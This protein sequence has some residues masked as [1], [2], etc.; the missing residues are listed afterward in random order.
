MIR[1]ERP[2]DPPA[3]LQTA[4]NRETS[5]ICKIYD[6]H[7]EKFRD[8]SKRF[9]FN[10]G[11]FG[12]T[13][14]KNALLRAQHGKCCFCESRFGATSYGE[15]EHFRP[16]GSVQQRRKQQTE[17]PGYFWLAYTWTNLL[18]ICNRC[19]TTHKRS[20]FPLVDDSARARSHHDDVDAEQPLFIN[21]VQ[22][23]PRQH[24]RFR[25]AAVVSI[26][27]RGKETIEGLGLRRD[28][29]EEARRE[30]LDYLRD[31]RDIV[32]ISELGGNVEAELVERARKRLKEA[33]EPNAEY[34]S[35]ARDVLDA[36]AE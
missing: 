26:T 34:S 2:P 33:L 8:G 30:T 19:N 16:K 5:E 17:Y 18:V 36:D 12:H 9:E 15:V 24:I 31:F 1:I 21:P 20:L 4:G 32:K 22:E 10:N 28:A 25:G 14:V 29:L 27:E 23:D 11:I 13:S 6:C 7:P 35:M 3:I